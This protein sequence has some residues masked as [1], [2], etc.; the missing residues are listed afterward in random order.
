MI[1]KL[2]RTKLARITILLAMAFLVSSH[3]PGQSLLSQPDKKIKAPNQGS[4]TTNQPTGASQSPSAQ[5]DPAAKPK[6]AKRGQ[7]VIA[8]IPIKSATLGSGLVLAAGY[9]F[10]L[11]QNDKLSPPSTVGLA[12]AFTNSGSRAGGIGAR[13]RF[14][15]N[16]YQTAFLLAKGR[17]NFDFFGIGRI[18]GRPGIR[19]PLKMGGTVFFSEFLRNIWKDVFVG[20]RYQYRN[21]YARLDGLQTP[22]GFEIPAID[23]K[24]K[25]VALGVHVQRD[26]RNST[27]YP[28][29]GSL[30]DITADYFDESLG[31]AREYQTYKV[32][33]NRYR[34]IKNKQVFAYRAMGCSA[35]GK[36]AFYDLCLYGTSS[37]LRGY[38]AGQFQNRRMFATQA[39]YR[40][41]LRKRLG[42]V[43]FGGVGGVAARLNEFRSD[44]LLPAGGAGLRFTLDKKNHI[45][46]RIDWAI[47][48]AGHTLTIGIG[49]SF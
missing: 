40:L 26:K 22:G 24:S 9:V 34:E 29:Q 44:Q 14:A 45:N 18:P 3:S 13:L 15:E 21:L 48:R 42:L 8:P 6:K 10:K 32:S 36:V 12:V 5:T 27:F 41:E 31:S 47:G 43:A 35:T 4:A 25:S 11:N 30:F 19:V 33:Y 38:A 46:Y 16:K 49:E 39:E 23:L 2:S 20:P 28:T 17:A 1:I 7:L 37:D